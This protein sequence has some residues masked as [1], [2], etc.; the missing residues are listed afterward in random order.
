[1]IVRF[2]IVRW[3]KMSTTM[4]SAA[5]VGR[6]D[7]LVVRSTSNRMI[8]VIVKPQMLCRLPP[9]GRSFLPSWYARPMDKAMPVSF[10]FI[11]V[12][13]AEQVSHAVC[14]HGY[15]QPDKSSD[16]CRAVCYTGSD[17]VT[18]TVCSRENFEGCW[19]GTW[20]S[21]FL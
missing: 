9:I 19:T 12:V 7:H 3:L 18:G 6:N 5:R 14:T 13:A 11:A 15:T 16:D 17:M 1:M 4:L 21:H 2:F 8:F 10:S 20:A